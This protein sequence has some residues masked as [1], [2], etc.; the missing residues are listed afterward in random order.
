MNSMHFFFIIKGSLKDKKGRFMV[1]IRH[2]S[3]TTYY[4]GRSELYKDWNFFDIHMGMMRYRD[5]EEWKCIYSDVHELHDITTT[6]ALIKNH[7]NEIIN[8][9]KRFVNTDELVGT[10]FKLF[11]PI[12]RI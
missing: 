4:D 6:N 11:T 2:Y 5:Y 1:Y 10:K 12:V 9:F 8:D 7:I 3:I